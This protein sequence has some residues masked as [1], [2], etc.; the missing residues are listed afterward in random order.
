MVVIYDDGIK[1]FELTEIRYNGLESAASELE[2]RTNIK[3]GDLGDNVYFVGLLS[4]GAVAGSGPLHAIVIA[5]GGKGA[6]V[7]EGIGSGSGSSPT[8]TVLLLAV[9]MIDA[10]LH[11]VL[12]APEGARE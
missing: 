6:F 10:V 8:V 4:S 1:Q 3:L 5:D 12:L 9:A 11:V 2:G 7:S